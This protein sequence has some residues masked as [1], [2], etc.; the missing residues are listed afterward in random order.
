MS[1]A[2]VTMTRQPTL[3][4]FDLIE[5][6]FAPLARGEPGAFGLRDDAAALVLPAGQSLVVTSDAMVE[7]VHFL[8]DDPP[9]TLGAKLLRVNLSDLAAMGAVPKTYTLTTILPDWVDGRWLTGFAGGLEADQ[10]A[11]GV[12]LVGGD[13]VKTPGPLTLSI[14]AMGA[15]PEGEALRRSGARVGDHIYVS[16]AIGGAALGLAVLQGRLTDMT[17]AAREVAI[18]RYRMP[19]PRLALGLA[20]RGIA[21]AAMDV[22]DGLLGDLAKLLRAADVGAELWINKVPLAAGLVTEGQPMDANLVDQGDD[23]ELLFT[24]PDENDAGMADMARDLDLAVTKIGRITAAQGLRV[25]DEKGRS[26]DAPA[27]GYRHF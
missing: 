22:S 1:W 11:F 18:R 25:L 7:G 8:R 14:T 20:L 17:Q 21:T 16:G 5:R 12:T 23:Y 2:G 24:I 4:E 15:F 3:D 13:T 10:I 27:V 19:E 26:I 6:F 9:E